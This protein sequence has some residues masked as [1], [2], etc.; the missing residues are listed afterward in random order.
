MLSRDQVLTLYTELLEHK[1]YQQI[2]DLIDCSIG[3]IHRY[4]AGKVANG[5]IRQCVTCNKD[6]VFVHRRKY[7][8]DECIPKS[9]KKRLWEDT[10][11]L[12]TVC[13][14]EFKPVNVVHIKCSRECKLL[15]DR[16]RSG[17]RN[18][19]YKPRQQLELMCVYCG[20]IFSAL[21]KDAR[22]CSHKCNVQYNRRTKAIGTFV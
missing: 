3:T 20:S 16:K 8:S 17:L 10:I 4:A 5:S 11:R 1:T 15:Y 7:C 21:R 2:A 19:T 6:Y 22:Y 13:K 18:R 12:C 9:V 14:N